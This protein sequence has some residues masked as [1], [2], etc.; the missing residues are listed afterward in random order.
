MLPEFYYDTIGKELNNQ[1]W[2]VTHSDAI[3]KEVVGNI[4]YSIF[5]MSESSNDQ[6]NQVRK[7]SHETEAESALIDLI[8]EFSSYN[9]GNKIVIFEGVDSEFDKYMTN[10]LF[11]EFESTIN[12]ISAG[13]KTNVYN[14]QNVL[15]TAADAGIISKKFISIVDKDFDKVIKNIDTSEFSWDVYHI[16]NYLLNEGYILKV[17]IDLGIETTELDSEEKI[18]DILKECARKTLAFHAHHELNLFVNRE[19]CDSIKTK[20]DESKSLSE[21][22]FGAVDSTIN[23][24]QGKKQNS[25]SKKNLYKKESIIKNKYNTSLTNDSW[26]IVFNGRNILKSFIG[27]YVDGIRYEQFR[28]LIIS[29]MKSEKFKP[30]GMSKIINQ[31]LSI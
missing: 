6:K 18:L 26:K 28:N 2:L 8:G 5:H 22:Y 30:E 3:L 9:H 7:I 25:L 19:I 24:I 27:T 12:S 31:I 21:E 11:P 17:L 23:E 16:E 13:S 10:T 4:N 15:K 29:K 20:I 1:I 14:L